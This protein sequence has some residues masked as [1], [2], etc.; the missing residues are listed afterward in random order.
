MAPKR[1]NDSSANHQSQ[2]VSF[3]ANVSEIINKFDMNQVTF[4]EI[5]ILNRKYGSMIMMYISKIL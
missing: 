5:I 2:W 1:L 4:L 3:K